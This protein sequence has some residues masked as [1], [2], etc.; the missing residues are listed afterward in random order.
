MSEVSGRAIAC[1]T[2]FP[3]TETFIFRSKE[4]L[5][6]SETGQ[7]CTGGECPPL[8][9]LLLA[10]IVRGLYS[11]NGTPVNGTFVLG[12]SRYVCGKRFSREPRECSKLLETVE[13]W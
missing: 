8:Q 11:H 2:R 9:P 10:T 1:A 5:L 4:T 6:N 13:L 3:P 7:N 12:E